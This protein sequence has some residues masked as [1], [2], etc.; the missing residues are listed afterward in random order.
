M[1]TKYKIPKE[2]EERGM[3]E[4]LDTIKEKIKRDLEENDGYDFFRMPYSSA[5]YM[6]E[7]GLIPFELFSEWVDR[8][9]K[10]GRLETFED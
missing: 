2:L 1:K 6:M 8:N 9:H 10:D 7:I 5:V 4:L 3:G